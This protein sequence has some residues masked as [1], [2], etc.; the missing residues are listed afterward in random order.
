MHVCHAG[1]IPVVQWLVEGRGNNK[2]DIHVRHAGRIPVV[3]RLI[4][5][6]GQTEHFIHVRH[7]GRIPKGNVGIEV[8][9]VLKEASKVNERRIKAP[10]LNWTVIDT[11][12]AKSKASTIAS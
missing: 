2:H 5:G 7:A 6:S 3:Q 1:R 9:F 11:G 10:V 8:S 12:S 4:E